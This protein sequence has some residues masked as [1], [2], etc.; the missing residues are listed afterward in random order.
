MTDAM[1]SDP[2]PVGHVGIFWLLKLGDVDEVSSARVF[3]LTPGIAVTFQRVG[4]ETMRLLAQAMGSAEHTQILPR[5]ERGKW[6][7]AG[8]LKEEIV[9]YG[10][11]TFDEEHIGELGL[12]IRLRKGEAYI[13]DCATLPAYRGQRLYPA[14][15]A[16]MLRALA[17]QGVHHVWLGTDAD[18]IPSQK[19][20]ALVG[21]R[22]VVDAGLVKAPAGQGRKSL[23]IRQRPGVSEQ[24]AMDAQRVLLGHL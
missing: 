22:P 10:W 15:L 9:T 20:V 19:G 11:V 23:W 7:Y 2:R 3:S 21:F 1:G 4:P 14:L 12:T 8:L 5:F 13:W 24:D 18:N 6:C 17:A 16:H